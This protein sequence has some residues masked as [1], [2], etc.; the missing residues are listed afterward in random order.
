MGTDG[1]GLGKDIAWRESAACLRYP[2]IL[3]FGH[4][5]SES[6]AERRARE[7][8]AKGICYS[9]SVR[10]QCLDYAL[11]TREPYGIW[12]G[13]TEIERRSRLHGRVG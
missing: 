1:R 11:R 13:L 3:F 5:D 7:E 4:E 9:C 12:G 2:G 6:A 10:R 8:Q